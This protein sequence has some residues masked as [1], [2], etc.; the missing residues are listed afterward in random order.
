MAKHVNAS[1]DDV[2]TEGAAQRAPRIFISYRRTDSFAVGRLA[3]GLS[4][5]FGKKTVFR[6]VSGIAPGE[7]FEDRILQELDSADVVIA[8]IGRT[9]LGQRTFGR[10]RIA[11]R[12]DWVRREVEHALGTGK[13]LIPVLL[14][15][16]PL[17]RPR[18]LPRTL[19][20]LTGVNARPMTDDNWAEEFKRLIETIRPL[21][22]NERPPENRI[23]ALWRQVEKIPGPARWPWIAAAGAATTVALALWVW[24]PI[25]GSIDLNDPSTW[26]A[27][28]ADQ[29]RS[30]VSHQALR[31]A[32]LEMHSDIAESTANN[33][34]F[35]V[36]KYLERFGLENQPWSVAFVTWTY[37]QGLR[38]VRNDGAARLPFTDTPAAARRAAS[39][40]RSGWFSEAVDVARIRSGDIV[41]LKHRDRIGHAEVV[42]ATT[43][44]QVCSIG[45]N[46]ANRVTGTCRPVGHRTFAGYAGVPATAY[47]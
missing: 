10:K 12:G 18:Q 26:T 25:G 15:G 20:S 29:A 22:Q 8:A 3:D 13:P 16:A 24:L 2:A 31:L 34:G 9:W 19:R 30:P 37:L 17:P 27:P 5:V 11:E 44:D 32:L 43:A 1:T 21:L 28:S 47:D 41:F 14:D 33:D 38:R 35:N 6:D 46:V 7:H 45:G 39:M 42:F 36:A 23:D 4:Q 40:K